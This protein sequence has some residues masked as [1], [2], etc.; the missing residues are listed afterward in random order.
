MARKIET[1]SLQAMAE[2]GNPLAALCL[3][4]R[5]IITSLQK[6]GASSELLRAE[7]AIR[8][9]QVEIDRLRAENA[10]LRSQ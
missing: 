8:G 4:Q 10:R 5:E 7:Q 3:R 2:G 9:L 6:E 1:A